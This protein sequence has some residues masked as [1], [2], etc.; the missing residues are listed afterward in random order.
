[1]RIFYTNERER[2]RIF[3]I[4]NVIRNYVARPCERK[5]EPVRLYSSSLPIRDT[6]ARSSRDK[7]ESL[8][9]QL[10]NY[11]IISFCSDSE[12]IRSLSSRIRDSNAPGIIGRRRIGPTR[13]LGSGLV[14]IIR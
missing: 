3:E 8:R 13:F 4:K 10:T 5:D 9:K 14:A 12:F 6:H 11:I 2:E 7:T 1:M